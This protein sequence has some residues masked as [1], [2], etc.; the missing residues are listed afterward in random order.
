MRDGADGCCILLLDLG[1][2]L[3]ASVQ[4]SVKAHGLGHVVTWF[5]YVHLDSYRLFEGYGRSCRSRSQSPS[6]CARHKKSRSD[7][8]LDQRNVLSVWT[9]CEE[10]DNML[11]V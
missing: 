8:E 10:D 7:A 5:D 1:S 6:R 11:Q 2:I 3:L 4:F 9:M